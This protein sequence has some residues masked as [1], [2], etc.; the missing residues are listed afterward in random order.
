MIM[1]ALTSSSDMPMSNGKSRF[2]RHVLIAYIVPG[3]IFAL[4]I[5]LAVLGI[6]AVEADRTDDA[7]VLIGGALAFALTASGLHGLLIVLRLRHSSDLSKTP[8]S[9]L[10]DIAILA[11]VILAMVPTLWLML[12][13]AYDPL[14]GIA[15]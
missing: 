9:V 4:A 6:R 2:G 14:R 1:P 8:I 12:W 15:G 3:S 7:I 10:S 5:V 13:L 11:T